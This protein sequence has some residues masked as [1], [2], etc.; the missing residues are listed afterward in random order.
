[1]SPFLIRDNNIINPRNAAKTN[2]KIPSIGKSNNNNPLP[3][4][5]INAD[6]M[7]IA[8]IIMAKEI[9]LVTLSSSFEIISKFLC[10]KFT[11]ILF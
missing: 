3:V 1:M 8:E 2:P 4:N 9:R 10:S 11:V 6:A 5:I 7:I